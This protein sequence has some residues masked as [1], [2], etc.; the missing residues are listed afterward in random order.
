MQKMAGV[1]ITYNVHDLVSKKLKFLNVNNK[2]INDD[3]NKSR[4]SR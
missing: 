4:G 3:V 1:L 2:E